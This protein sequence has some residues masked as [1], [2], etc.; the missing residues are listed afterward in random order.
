[1][2]LPGG[3]FLEQR[4]LSVGFVVV[5]SVFSPPGLVIEDGTAVE[6]GRYFIFVG[7]DCLKI[8][9]GFVARFDRTDKALQA[10]KAFKFFPTVYA[11]IAY[12]CPVECGS[13]EVEGLVIRFQRDGEWMTIL[14]AVCE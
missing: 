1:M 10:A 4:A 8:G 7:D 3:G 14:A 2:L 11:I 12:V 5:G 13:K 6:C 9:F